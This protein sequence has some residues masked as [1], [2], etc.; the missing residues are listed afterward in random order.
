MALTPTEEALV[1]QLLDQQAAILSLA[2]NE[3]TITS[4]L[5]ATKV[6]LSDLLAA[7]EV[8]NTD[9]FLTRQGTSDKSVSGLILKNALTSFTQQGSGAVARTAEGK[10]QES[11]SV[12]DFGAVGDGVTDDTAAIQ[13][14]IT[15]SYGK[16]LKVLQGNYRLTS[17][18]TATEAIHLELDPESVLDFSGAPVGAALGQQIA[19]RFSGTAPGAAVTVTAN[20]AARATSIQLTDVAGLAADDWIVVRSDDAYISGGDPLD[21]TLGHIAR[22]RSVDSGVQIT[23]WEASPFAYTAASNAR[24]A[25][26]TPLLGAKVTGGRILC[27]GVGSAHSA[28]RFNYCDTPV[29]QGVQIDSAEDTGVSYANCI[30]PQAVGNVITKSTSPGGAIGNAGYGI[31]IYGGKGGRASGN[32]IFNCRHAVAGGA[33]NGVL[34]LGYEFVGND[35]F[36]CGNASALTWAL[37]CHEPCYNWKFIG[38]TIE[39]CHGGAVLRGPGTVFSLNTIRDTVVGGVHVQQFANNT[40]GLPRI[41]VT[42]NVI[43]NTG[44]NAI[45]ALGHNSTASDKIL[46]LIVSGNQISG[47][48]DH[49]ILLDYA[50]GAVVSGNVIANTGGATRNAILLRN[51]ERVSI[52]GGHIDCSLPTNGNGIQIEN[53]DRITVNGVHILGSGAATNQDGVRSS[54]SGSND[55]I[56]INGCFIGGFSRYAIYT[57]NSDRVIVTNN[58]VRDVASATKILLTGVVTSVNANN[59]T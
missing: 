2:V 36:A 29:C 6:T 39:G 28:V 17:G 22:I 7:S 10:L 33:F 45:R 35:A 11:V 12:K 55:T 25:K 24:I 42:D 9:L 34:S 16:R 41:T 51:S 59:I 1:R 14:A 50:F 54:G 4:K 43:E 26:F 57:T 18:L 19:L 3:A 56:I 47:S 58:D 31:A 27:G 5:A 37:D 40:T 48:G 32:R 44:S 23:V 46:Q 15:A 38:N 13:A 21:Y 30:S 49:P 53:S 52:N 20:I 8:G